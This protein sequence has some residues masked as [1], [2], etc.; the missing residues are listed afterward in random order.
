M[1]ETLHSARAKARILLDK[2]VQGREKLEAENQGNFESCQQNAAEDARCL[3]E[4]KKRKCYVRKC[5]VCLNLKFKLVP[6]NCQKFN[7][8][9]VFKKKTPKKK[10]KKKKKKK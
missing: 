1:G 10:K 7:K 8:K 3:S 5:Y 9:I 6:N 4:Q 2:S